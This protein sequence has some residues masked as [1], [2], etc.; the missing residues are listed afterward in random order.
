MQA[1]VLARL[2]GA[3]TD[4]TM[5]VPRI[6][7]MTDDERLVDPTPVIPSLPPGS[8]VIVRSRSAIDRKQRARAISD[9]C[10]RRQIILL[11]SCE[12]PP[13][14]L[15][16]DGVHIPEAGRTQ[17]RRCDFWRLQPRLITTSAHDL[18][19]AQHAAQWGADAVLLSPLRPTR[20]HPSGKSLGYWRGATICHH[21]DIPT[22]AL[23]GVDQKSMARIIDLGFYGCA[24]IDIFQTPSAPT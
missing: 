5:D 20:S 3:Q 1:P 24:G 22:I 18:K 19:S 4:H 23:G 14:Q 7:L 15:I 6:I 13:K 2:L 9:L 11:V 17:W 10:R 12:V 21:I 16:G 8:A